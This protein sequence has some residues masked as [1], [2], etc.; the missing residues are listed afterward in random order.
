MIDVDEET[1][2]PTNFRIFYMDLVMANNSGTPEWVQLIDYVKD[3]DLTQGMSPDSLY[4]LTVR[5]T[6]DV[7]LF[8]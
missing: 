6:Q 8:W 2:L 5:L 1:M 4:R 3:Y 7:D